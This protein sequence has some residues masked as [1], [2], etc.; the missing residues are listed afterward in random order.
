MIK[1]LNA[2]RFFAF[3]AVYL[4]HAQ[5]L[6]IGHLGVSAFFVLSGFLIIPILREMKDKNTS[7][8]FLKFYGRRSVR[9]FPLYY[10]YLLLV[11]T[12][13]FT[14]V[15]Q[16]GYFR[17]FFKQIPYAI[18][19]CYNFYRASPQFIYSP[20]LT[21]F[22][23]LAVEEQFY[24]IFPFIVFFTPKEKLKNV[25]LF[26]IIVSPILR[27]LFLE[28]ITSAQ[29]HSLN[30][31]PYAVVQV[32]TTSHF[33]AF[34]I[35]GFF[36]LYVKKQKPI[37]TWILIA[38]FIAVGL[39]TQK[40]A[41]GKYNLQDMDAG[42]PLFMK[43]SYKAI[44]GYSFAN[45]ISA[46]IIINIRAGNFITPVFNN[47]VINYLGKISYGLYVYHLPIM[48]FVSKVPFS[49]LVVELLSLSSTIVISILSYELFE[50]RFLIL[51]NQLFPVVKTS[52]DLLL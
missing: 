5:I 34:A 44:W 1:G 48:H 30:K 3:L 50:K 12:L 15:V 27:L 37:Y 22:W 19:Y 10:L 39:I 51:K 42:Y 29:V 31:D 9:I 52:Q 40:M 26:F 24:L 14:H 16:D 28:F 46:F 23:T 8:Y 25:L 36:A 17:G 18:F 33:D 21:H 47:N 43:D 2:F 7:N 41:T 32:L 49:A 11:I 4:F 6:G 20:L 45:L 13:I 38:L 35:G